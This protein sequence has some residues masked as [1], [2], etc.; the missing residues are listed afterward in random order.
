MPL[1]KIIMIPH[2]FISHIHVLMDSVVGV[3]GCVLT[4]GTG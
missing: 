2:S 3:D 1:S 4:E